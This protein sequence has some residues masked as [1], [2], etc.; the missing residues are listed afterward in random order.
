MDGT[1]AEKVDNKEF[2]L[3]YKERL[4]EVHTWWEVP[5]IAHFCSLFKAVFG[6]SDFDIEDLEE[7]LLT[8]PTLGGSTLVIDIICQ[9]LNGCYARDD[10][11]YFNYDLFLKDIFKQRW[12]QELGRPSPLAKTTF[13]EL[14]IRQRVEILHA[15]CDFRLD[16]DDVAEMLKGLSGDS[17]RVEPLGVDGEG[18]KYWYF[19]GT[20]LYKEVS[21]TDVN[22]EIANIKTIRKNQHVD[23]DFNNIADEE[24]EASQHEDA[25]DGAKRNPKLTAQAE[26]VDNG[27][28]NDEEI[29]DEETGEDDI[30]ENTSDNVQEEDEFQRE[31][32]EALQESDDEMMD[33]DKNDVDFEE[34]LKKKKKSQ[35]KQKKSTVKKT[36][37]K[38]SCKAEDEPQYIEAVCKAKRKTKH[39]KGRR[40]KGKRRS[41]STS[42]SKEKN[43]ELEPKS[44]KRSKSATAS[45]KEASTPTP[46]RRSRRKLANDEVP[47]MIFPASISKTELKRLT[48]D[49]FQNQLSS[50]LSHNTSR[51]SSVSCDNVK[52]ISC[53]SSLSG[54]G[55]KGCKGAAVHRKKLEQAVNQLNSRLEKSENVEFEAS[56][57]G[58]V[59]C[60]PSKRGRSRRKSLP[61]RRQ[62]KQDLGEGA[63]Q[64]TSSGKDLSSLAEQEI[65]KSP[66]ID[67]SN[68]ELCPP[69]EDQREVQSASQENISASGT[70]SFPTNHTAGTD[71][72]P[73]SPTEITIVGI[74]HE[75]NSS[76]CDTGKKEPAFVGDLALSNDTPE[77]AV[78]SEDIRTEAGAETRCGPTNAGLFDGTEGEIE[79]AKNEDDVDTK[80]HNG[81]EDD[82][83]TKDH[84][85]CEEE[86]EERII[87]L[88]EADL[89]DEINLNEGEWRTPEDL[90][91]G[92]K[93][94]TGDNMEVPDSRSDGIE[95]TIDFEQVRLCAE[96]VTES[97]SLSVSTCDSGIDITHLSVCPSNPSVTDAS[98]DLPQREDNGEKVHF[99]TMADLKGADTR[100][101]R[102]DIQA[103]MVMSAPATTPDDHHNNQ[104][105]HVRENEELNSSLSTDLSLDVSGLTTTVEMSKD[106]TEMEDI[107]EEEED[108]EMKLKVME[109]LGLEVN[110]A[111]YAD[112]KR[113]SAQRKLNKQLTQPLVKETSV[114]HLTHGALTKRKLLRETEVPENVSPLDM[115]VSE[116][117]TEPVTPT[118][119]H[120]V[121][122]AK[123]EGKEMIQCSITEHDLV[124]HKALDDV[125]N[126]T[127]SIVCEMVD[128]AFEPAVICEAVNISQPKEA[129]TECISLNVTT[130]VPDSSPI[131]TDISDS[132]S[133]TTD[134]LDSSPVTTNV[135]DSSP[136]TTNVSDNSAVTT[137]VPDSSAVTT[138]V[139]DSSSVTTDVPDS[140]A[141]EEMT[142]VIVTGVLVQL[143]EDVV[144]THDQKS[145]SVEHENEIADNV[146]TAGGSENSPSED[147]TDTAEITL[148]LKGECESDLAAVSIE[149]HLSE[150]KMVDS[151][152]GELVVAQCDS[153]EISLDQRA[154]S[155]SHQLTSDSNFRIEEAEMEV[156]K[157]SSLV[158]ESNEVDRQ[159]KAESKLALSL[160]SVGERDISVDAEVKEDIAANRT[161]SQD[162]VTEVFLDRDLTNEKSD[163]SGV[164]A[165]Y[166]T[167]ISTSSM[168]VS[169]EE[170][171][172]IVLRDT[173][174]V[175]MME[176]DKLSETKSPATYQ[177]I[178]CYC[179]VST[180]ELDSTLNNELPAEDQETLCEAELSSTSL[181]SDAP[182]ASLDSP[183][184]NELTVTYQDALCQR[185]LSASPQAAPHC[186]TES[187][188]GHN[189]ASIEHE[190]MAL[191]QDEAITT[192][193]KESEVPATYIEPL[194]EK[195]MLT[196]YQ[197]TPSESEILSMNQ[198][199]PSESE[200]LSMNQDAPCKSEM[201][202]TNLDTSCEN[203]VLVT[204]YQTPC[205][206]EVM[207][208]NQNEQ[209]I[210]E[211]SPLFQN[212]LFESDLQT[213]SPD[214]P[215]SAISPNTAVE[216]MQTTY[217]CEEELSLQEAEQLSLHNEKPD[218]TSS[219]T[220]GNL[221]T[222]ENSN[223]CHGILNETCIMDDV[224]TIDVTN[225]TT[226]NVSDTV[227][228]DNQSILIEN[229][230]ADRETEVVSNCEKDFVHVTQSEDSCIGH[231][232][233]TAADVVSDQNGLSTSDVL[234][235][236]VSSMSQSS[237]SVE[238]SE[239]KKLEMPMEVKEEIEE[240]AEIDLEGLSVVEMKV[241]DERELH[242]VPLYP[243]EK[244]FRKGLSCWQL[245]CDSVEDWSKLT[246]ELK[247]S[248]I[249]REK[250]LYRILKN[251]FMPAIPGIMI[252]K[253]KARKL[254]EKEMMPKRSSYRLELKKLEE[255]QKERLQREEE[256]VEEK[257][258]AI[259]EEERRQQLKLEDEKRQKEEKERARAERA[260]RARLREERARLIAEGKE[261][262]AELMNGLR[263]DDNDDDVD[264]EMQHNF[265]KVLWTIKCNEHSW[266]FLEAVEEVNTPDFF[267]MIKE[268]MDLLKIQRKLSE[269]GYKSREEFEKDMNLVFDN[270]I[271]YH[272]DDSDFGYMAQNLKG[273]FERSIRRTFRV[274]LE[275]QAHKS[276]RRRDVLGESTYISEYAYSG[277]RS[278]RKRPRNHSDSDSD[279]E[280]YI[281]GRIMYPSG[282]KWGTEDETEMK[283]DTAKNSEEDED[284]KL[285][286]RAT[287]SYR[288][289]LLGN[290]AANF[291]SYIPKSNRQ[292]KDADTADPAKLKRMS[293]DFSKYPGAK[294]RYSTPI[295]DGPYKRSCYIVN[296]Y[297]KKPKVKENT[298]AVA[299]N[300][301]AITPAGAPLAAAGKPPVKVVKISRE[302][303]EK[304]LAENKITIVDSNSPAGQVIKLKA[305]LQIKE[306]NAA[307]AAAKPAILTSAGVSPDPAPAQA[308]STEKNEF[309]KKGESATPA[310]DIKERLRK[311]NEKLAR[312]LKSPITKEEI[313]CTNS[314]IVRGQIIF[315]VPPDKM[316]GQV[317]LS[318][319]DFTPSP[320]NYKHHHTSL[321]C[322][323][324]F[325]TPIPQEKT[326]P[327]KK[328]RFSDEIIPLKKGCLEMN[329]A[330]A[331][332]NNEHSNDDL[333]FKKRLQ[334][335]PLKKSAPEVKNVS[336]STSSSALT[337]KATSSEHSIYDKW[338]RRAK[339][340]I[341]LLSCDSEVKI[342]KRHREHSF[343]STDIDPPCKYPKLEVMGHSKRT[344]CAFNPENLLSTSAEESSDS[345][346]DHKRLQSETEKNS[347]TELNNDLEK[348]PFF[349]SS[350]LDHKFT[351]DSKEEPP[352][353][354]S[355]TSSPAELTTESAMPPNTSSSSVSCHTPTTFRL[356]GLTSQLAQAMSQKKK[357]VL[358]ES[359]IE[360]CE[361]PCSPPLLEPMGDAVDLREARDSTPEDDEMPI[362]VPDHLP[363][364]L[365]EP[366]MDNIFQR[367]M[368]PEKS[369]I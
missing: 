217:H 193:Q 306:T 194:C 38:S 154:V 246:E 30:E 267:E 135:S 178:P 326:P 100:G 11:K 220:T 77:A 187:P 209:M 257:Q 363:P 248:T 101:H 274:Y 287:W 12:Q 99:E 175:Q 302:E 364:T 310:L 270:C 322:N 188:S 104:Q 89:E 47:E 26:M 52:N 249:Y 259:A 123:C 294:F 255:E 144:C 124:A 331:Y 71:N 268:P 2:D 339:K 131:T 230:Q 6:F 121:L 122:N 119:D 305:G 271:E 92:I 39:F 344:D 139:P 4:N 163:V 314:K 41:R 235:D 343:S 238:V 150:H 293:V 84:I 328:V 223:I 10:I 53:N 60:N 208:P 136:V 309:T 129:P 211:V 67:E 19:Y 168:A 324:E 250:Q 147:K 261:I 229:D 117:V 126:T 337:S 367:M 277:S 349:E 56:E 332:K 133:V 113:R 142:T 254:R 202:I 362:L 341:E 51:E 315:N 85:G 76:I 156:D 241:K 137:D 165:A 155:V 91:S 45:D 308:L 81:S 141:V 226:N 323:Q 159:V 65:L 180:I 198:D 278:S 298:T 203:E 304:L 189:D 338:K 125:S 66:L 200:I 284:P 210:S 281:T 54:E 151:I 149:S 307:T 103:I 110:K 171:L 251:D 292:N 282:R 301:A 86:E 219:L 199:A 295:I 158:L 17:L 365:V 173:A 319:K 197:E 239:D 236:S 61:H 179:K 348:I 330:T 192:H 354:K 82:V 368:N 356:S 311:V 34:E 224:T 352:C 300:S 285:T 288:R 291:E 120:Q 111:M 36:D 138:D 218:E 279:P 191:H 185:E 40:S 321:Y 73:P 231:Q 25:E 350:E 184:E 105:Y 3:D 145:S 283:K 225:D 32:N 190:F 169:Q 206:S 221:K 320:T 232:H 93:I 127:S 244:P 355:F 114:V 205:A 90:T 43:G 74:T 351:S 336:H 118:N 273:V 182:M 87:E 9:L 290:E 340:S 94:E 116:L 345:P 148:S 7:A 334:D 152:S 97:G 95:K 72:A 369:Q 55:A 303:Y 177:D 242:R 96:N 15:L 59:S 325:V 20:R 316:G 280:P 75:D 333:E 23:N 164:R 297:V 327:I 176:Q 366:G 263:H 35:R 98:S 318:G 1:D 240:K 78:D 172:S 140:S 162:D 161:S 128:L 48:I 146:S 44:K 359:V 83:G 216:E 361:S 183:S 275:P 213:S 335:S 70:T 353:S 262:P 253:E 360:N 234:F 204:Y 260:N 8:S 31:L 5:A 252:D 69:Y 28:G 313:V 347:T 50:H 186:E 170:K 266:P 276:S 222:N 312:R 16:A 212:A 46:T 245:V 214:N 106:H 227:S 57:N 269:R 108:E 196:T 42:L 166:E 132:L 181:A 21:D 243:D 160:D 13:L 18:A 134:V 357:P 207:V 296:Q 272:G 153:E 157:C 167:D 174:V 247:A 201:S 115:Y 264:E 22:K 27:K 346:M 256:E 329:D 102:V 58:S 143:L 68:Q 49:G 258:R 80:D 109:N 88:H 289:E 107:V 317:T 112:R 237:L 33:D 14:P 233:S 63:L 228:L 342:R 79:K 64:L 358:G 130:D 29:D 37:G 299:Q 24:V 265:E 62:Y 286:P 195:K 215:L